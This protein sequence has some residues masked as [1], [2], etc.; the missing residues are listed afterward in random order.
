[1]QRMFSPWLAARSKLL[2]GL[3]HKL[4]KAGC[5]RT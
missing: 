3:N 4:S 2:K 5:S 1:L